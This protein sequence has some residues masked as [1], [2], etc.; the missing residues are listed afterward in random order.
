[1]PEFSPKMKT[2]FEKIGEITYER[3][4]KAIQPSLKAS[5]EAVNTSSSLDNTLEGLFGRPIEPHIS[6]YDSS[7]PSLDRVNKNAC[8]FCDM[9]TFLKI[10]SKV[11][12]DGFRD[13]GLLEHD[14]LDA[15]DTRGR[16]VIYLTAMQTARYRTHSFGVLI[17]KG[18]CRLLH[19]TLSEITVTRA[20]SISETE[21]LQTF[22]WLLSHAF[23]AQRGIDT[24]YE[25]NAANDL[26]RHSLNVQHAQPVWLV[27]AGN[28]EFYVAAPFT[29]SRIYPIGR[30]TRCFIAVDKLTMQKC[31]LKDIWR[32]DAYHAEG[33]VYAEL[34]KNGV[35]NIPTIL[36]DGEV[37]SNAKA[38]H[39]CGT[40]PPGWNVPPSIRRHIHYRIVFGVVG[41]P[42]LDFRSTH[43]LSY[44]ILGAVGHG[45][46]DRGDSV[47]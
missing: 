20:L 30:G 12:Y 42:L 13:E 9:E 24:T 41:R 39:S 11:D 47:Q 29:R 7:I 44:A 2:A 19:H 15:L 28:R 8:R 36:A 17:V 34:K 38:Y 31:V 40:F 37:G 27:A 18:Q 32:I 45:R 21:H 35:R 33:E 46:G 43:E 25:L 14:S 1:M 26:D 10:K 3:K 22:F 6:L 16:I 5:W 4:I 23:P